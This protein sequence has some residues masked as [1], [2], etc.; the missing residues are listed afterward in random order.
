[1]K[2][3]QVS[4]LAHPSKIP[5]TTDL[6]VPEPKEGQVLVDVYAAGLNFFDILQAQGLYQT[7]PPLPFILGA[8]FAGR[9]SAS[10][11][12]PTGC[13]YKPGD[14]VFGYT[15]GAFA[16]HI[17]VHPKVL[18]PI[19]RGISFEQAS[20]IPLT[21]GTSFFGIVE[22]A[23]AKS[24]EWVLIHAG[25]GGVGIAA[26]QI[27]KA[28]GCKVIATASSEDK[29]RICTERGGVDAVV[30]YSKDGWQKQVMDITNGKGVDVV[31]DPVGLILPS[32]KC[33]AWNAR[34]VVVGFAA[35][36]I[37][38]IPA[39]LIL[40]KQVSIVG[41]F[42][43][44]TA[45]KRDPKTGEKVMRGLLE[46]LSK[47]KFKP[48]T[49]EPQLLGLERVSEGLKKLEDRKVWGRAVVSIKQDHQAKL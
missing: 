43:G 19:P 34:I 40:L 39:N 44:E 36:N 31:Y 21:Y 29:R 18:L 6:P 9:I 8:E 20:A 1:M 46:M 38:K 3:F 37:E 13:P 17:C 16:E 5:L 25:A 4:Q 48:V 14:K 32:L 24:G 23:Q 12:I 45:G 42:W 30:D 26:C 49:Y 35:G 2:A 47:G 10:S 11:P 27:A 7:K 15:Q 22:R 41:L 28:V 33:T